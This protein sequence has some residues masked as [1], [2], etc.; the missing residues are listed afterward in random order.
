MTRDSNTKL[1]KKNN[2]KYDK[3]YNKK[4]DESSDSESD[5]ET[6][7]ESEEEEHEEEM[8]VHELRKYISTIFPSKHLNKKIKAGEKFK[9]LLDDES[10]ESDDSDS[11]YVPPKK[12][13]KKLRNKKKVESESEEEESEEY[14]E[15]E[16]EE[17]SEEYEEEEE[18]EE[19]EESEEESEEEEKPKKKTRKHRNKKKVIESESE[20]ED[21]EEDE[22]EESE[23]EKPSKK[24]KS[25]KVNIIFTIGNKKGDEDGDWENEEYYEANREESEE[26]EDT[27]DEDE[28]V[29][30]DDDDESES[31][32]DEEL[33]KRKSTRQN[34]NKKGNNNN[35]KTKT[36][37]KT[38]S[39]NKTKSD[40]KPKTDDE[41]NK[42]TSIKSEES[43]P[44]KNLRALLEA[45]PKDKSI[46]KC[47]DM[48][49]ADLK[50]QKV[51]QDKKESKQ[52]S[53]NLRIFKKIIKDKNTMNDF[54]VYEKFN[55]TEQKKLIKELKEINKITRIEKPYR[56]TILESD[57]PIE[58]KAAALKK[59]NSLRCM[60][61]GSG[62]FY[63]IK[64][65]VDT[66]MRIPFNKTIDLPLS[67]E[68][69]VEKCHDFMESA[70]KTLDEAIYGLNDAKIQIMQML[71]QLLTNPKSIGTAIAIHGPPG[72]GKCHTYDTPILMH[73]GSIKMVQ[74]IVIGDVVMG[75]DSCPRNVTDLGRD[76]DELYEIV[77]SRGEKFGVNSE[78]I[79]CLKQCGLNK[80][81]ES[82]LNGQII[83]KVQYFDNALQ[84]KT[85]TSL[86]DAEQFLD[87]QNNQH[88]VI[89]M[90]VK[91]LLALPKSVS[92]KLKGYKTGVTFQ[93]KEVP[94]DSYILG[95]WL[96]D[97]SSS[98]N[99]VTLQD[100]NIVDYIKDTI[101]N[102]QLVL[103]S[104]SQYSYKL[105]TV[106]SSDEN[107]KFLQVLEQ[108]DLQNNKHIP[109]DYKINDRQTQL[110]LLAGIIDENGNYNKIHHYFETIQKN[111][112]L[113]DDILFVARS[114]GF[115][116]YQSTVVK[117][118]LYKGE[119]KTC[120]YYRVNIYG[121]LSE[122]PTKCVHKQIKENVNTNVNINNNLFSFD[123][124]PIGRGKYYGFTLDDNHRYLLGNFT[125]THNTSLVKEGISK[126]LNRP[127]AFIA[128]GGATDSSFLEGH[129]YTYEGSTWGKIVQILI[130]S[131]CMN[132]VIYFDELDKISD[133]PKGEEI[134]GILTHLTDTSQ[135]SQFHDKYF[136]EINFDLS[137]CL[138]IFSYNDE[139][140]VS[141][142]LRD[143]MYR[144]KTKGYSGKEKTI[145]SN[146]YLLPKIREQVKFNVNDIIIPDVTLT[147]IIETYCGKEDGVRNMK[148]C[149]EII[150]TKINLFRLMR[151]GSKLF[152]YNM[153][154][155]V[156]F[157]FTVTKDIVDKLIKREEDALGWCSLYV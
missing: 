8:D 5:Y 32:E 71:G 107:N 67:I 42:E 113:S 106:H 129:G 24:S 101:S 58:F 68:D 124:K 81:K 137:K 48:Y 63:K 85:F 27:E 87:K 111:K 13:S 97:I 77:P 10:Y 73:D 119:Q 94:F 62:E 11:D 134:V 128:L 130:D 22:D 155:K 21:E 142:I 133:T 84:D 145:I 88:E 52:K 86:Y 148:R 16:E 144:I 19:D 79:L 118:Y 149:L 108:Y 28:S 74:D 26:S 125:V 60:E 151:P 122:I 135:N 38:K 99:E 56:M 98:K 53:K 112:Q 31:S 132:P 37:D 59:I 126:I 104:S 23:E 83:Y 20:E 116:A 18:E 80:I 69:G 117:S 44:L 30:S 139:S 141:H 75:D 76:E 61:P 96:A 152:D 45:N 33:Q 92:D 136:A 89:E 156:E 4:R 7:T 138:F 39:D 157:P 146:N 29:S 120:D 2:K 1:S 115:T 102:Y 103:N 82:K 95:I 131:K 72:T 90:S 41:K 54:S 123:I 153:S 3:K 43:E 6:V 127:F 154:L 9:K 143:R 140:K 34:K 109:S 114:L 147:H 110:Q 100:D 91:D 49:E 15:E 93:N 50:K 66:F 36:D 46:K 51:K 78:H 64:N 57:I 17:E 150:Y 55:P 121:A 105:D 35:N 14:E 12:K 70:Q 47:I 40:E 25:N 65:W